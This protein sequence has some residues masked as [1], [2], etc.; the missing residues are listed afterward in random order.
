MT[1]K[2]QKLFIQ[3][4]PLNIY[5]VSVVVCA[6]DGLQDYLTDNYKPYR[7]EN[8]SN[9]FFIPQEGIEAT[10]I[11]AVDKKGDYTLIIVLV[12]EDIGASVM[13]HEA[14]HAALCVFDFVHAEP[15][16][17]NQEPFAYLVGYI[18]KIINFSYYKWYGKTSTD[19]NK[20]I[21]K[22]SD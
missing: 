10:C 6:G 5:P 3:E 22:K 9:Y 13:A 7:D 2:K 17:D 4:F 20:A 1:K 14:T 12:K 11:E 18:T 16:Y 15:D 8:N 21:K 19:Y